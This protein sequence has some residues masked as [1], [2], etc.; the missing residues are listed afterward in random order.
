MSQVPQ[1]LATRFTFSVDGIGN[2][3]LAWD[4]ANPQGRAEVNNS[5][6]QAKATFTGLPSLN[7]DFGLKTARLLFDGTVFTDAKLEVFYLAT[8]TNHPPSQD[9]YDFSEG[10]TPNVFFYSV[11]ILRPGNGYSPY[12]PFRFVSGI[13]QPYVDTQYQDGVGW[14]YPMT[15]GGGQ[16]YIDPVGAIAHENQHIFN[17]FV[18]VWGSQQLKQSGD[19]SDSDDLKDS[20]EVSKYGNLSKG[21]QEYFDDFDEP[22]AQEAPSKLPKALREDQSWQVP[23]PNL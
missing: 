20:W 11:Q 9:P 1:S 10:D 2:S 3:T 6:L 12:V 19:D 23:G 8:A 7:S 22:L 18:T 4:D 21:W 17:H 14:G 15:L 5:R 13:T 16:F